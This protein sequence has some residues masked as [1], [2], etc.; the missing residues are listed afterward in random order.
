MYLQATATGQLALCASY[1]AT[2]RYIIHANEPDK[3]KLIS[4]THSKLLAI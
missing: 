2:Y 4:Q 3:L 1:M